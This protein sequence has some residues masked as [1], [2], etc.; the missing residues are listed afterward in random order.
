MRVDIDRLRRQRKKQNTA[1]AFVRHAAQG[2]EQGAAQKFVAHEAPVDIKKLPRAF[3]G[4]PSRGEKT[5]PRKE[6]PPASSSIGIAPR[7]TSP[8]SATSA[9]QC[10]PAANRKRAA[11][12]RIR[13][14]DRRLGQRDAHERHPTMRGFGRGTAQKAPAS[15]HRREQIARGDFRPER[16]RERTRDSARPA[17]RRAVGRAARAA[18]NRQFGGGGAQTRQRLAAK[19]QCRN[20]DQIAAT[21]ILLV[22]WRAAARGKSSGRMP[23]PSS[24]TSIFLIPPSFDGDINFVGA[25]VDGVFDQFFERRRR[26]LDDL[27][28]GDEIRDRRRQGSQFVA[29]AKGAST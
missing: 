10:R 27:A 21:R 18:N 28:R 17:N 14:R 7:L 22:A 9:N 16:R 4:R 13:K 11:R 23:Q 20:G 2:V 5:R 3:R 19:T 8:N 24:A 1:A 6:I 15:R 26:A 29:A 12:D 25:G